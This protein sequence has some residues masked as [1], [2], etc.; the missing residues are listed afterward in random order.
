MRKF[1]LLLPILALCL[2]NICHATD[3]NGDELL[4]FISLTPYTV[5]QIKV[6]SI[7]GQP[8]SVEESARRVWWYYKYGSSKLTISWNKKSESLERFS[9]TSEQG[10]KCIFDKNLSTKLKSGKTDIVSA[11]KILGTPI[12]LTIRA[13]T[14]EMHYAYVNKRL[15]LFFRDRKLVDFCLY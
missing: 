2:Q 3:H 1:M 9:F 13:S 4:K 7:L 10:E 6:T 8:V 12:D 14:Q 11:L 15:R 5:T